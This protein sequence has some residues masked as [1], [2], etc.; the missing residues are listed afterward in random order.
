MKTLGLPHWTEG[1]G[2]TH[3]AQT[4]LNLSKCTQ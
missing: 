2:A 1:H 4:D 3:N